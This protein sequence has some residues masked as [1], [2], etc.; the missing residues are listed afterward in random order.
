MGTGFAHARE[1]IKI[2]MHLSA[3]LKGHIHR[4]VLLPWWIVFFLGHLGCHMQTTRA[5]RIWHAATSQRAY[6]LISLASFFSYTPRAC[7]ERRVSYA[8]GIRVTG[9]LANTGAVSE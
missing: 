7:F 3:R 1:K 5:Q 9:P 4:K 6:S 2:H 8:L